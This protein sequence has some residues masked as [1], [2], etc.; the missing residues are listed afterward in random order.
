MTS[1]GL[2][3]HIQSERLDR[4]EKTTNDLA[5]GVA[6]QRVEIG[7]LNTQIEIGHA[8]ILEKLDSISNNLSDKLVVVSSTLEKVAQKE[9]KN[10]KRLD[11]IEI[12]D[13]VYNKLKKSFM[14]IVLALF[15]GAGALLVEQLIRHR[16][17]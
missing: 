3:S 11:S 14:G 7:A 16:G 13:K 8:H 10:E 15:S 17:Q 1:N 12:K 2:D 4:V 6:S 5:I 9:E